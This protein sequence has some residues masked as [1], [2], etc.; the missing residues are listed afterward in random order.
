M[1]LGGYQ[2][3]LKS[4]CFPERSWIRFLGSLPSDLPGNSLSPLLIVRIKVGLDPATIHEPL[5]SIVTVCIA[6]SP[7]LETQV[8]LIMAE[9][10]LLRGCSLLLWLTSDCLPELIITSTSRSDLLSLD[11]LFILIGPLGSIITTRWSIVY[12][13]FHLKHYRAE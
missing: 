6:F 11:Y 5:F 10:R 8:I 3:G 2:F 7:T 9:Q 13:I 12:I 1:L 4:W